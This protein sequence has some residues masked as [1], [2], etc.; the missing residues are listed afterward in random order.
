MI[1]ASIPEKSLRAS[2]YICAEAQEAL[3]YVRTK[4]K[5]ALTSLI[6]RRGQKRQKKPQTDFFMRKFISF[7]DYNNRI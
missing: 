6:N 4:N 3:L 7:T 1:S 5:Q 2:T